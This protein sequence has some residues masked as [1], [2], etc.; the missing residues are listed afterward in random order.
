MSASVLNQELLNKLLSGNEV[1]LIFIWG[2]FMWKNEDDSKNKYMKTGA[3]CFP[4]L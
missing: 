1:F 4:K 3:I 2:G